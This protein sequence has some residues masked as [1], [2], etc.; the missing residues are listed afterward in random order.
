MHA[1]P[2]VRCSPHPYS[3]CRW[4]RSSASTRAERR[5]DVHFEVLAERI[6]LGAGKREAALVPWIER[7]VRRLEAHARQAPYN[8]FNFYDFWQDA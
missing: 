3:A 1:S 5:Y 4:W 6:E 2:P 8:W 7:Y